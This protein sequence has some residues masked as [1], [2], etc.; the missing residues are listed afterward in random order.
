VPVRIESR[1]A[2]FVL[3]VL[4]FLASHVLTV[5]TPVGKKVR[6]HVL[7]GGAPLI[8]VKSDDLLAAG[9]ERV[10]KTVGVRGGLPVLEDDRV[11]DVANVIWCTG[12][13][14]DFSWIDVPIFDDD[15]DPM[16]ER[17]V[18]GDQ[19]LYFVGRDFQYSFVSENVGGVGRDAKYI[20]KRIASR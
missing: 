16:L 4:W 17:G 19:G 18:A 5:K 7:A 14:E 11:L 1:K 8:R 3:P 6:P 12:F 15:G 20:V 10:P 13:K 9:I 2:R